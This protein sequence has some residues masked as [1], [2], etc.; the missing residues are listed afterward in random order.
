MDA[1][2]PVGPARPA[3][4]RMNQRGEPDVLDGP[5]RRRS[6][7]PRVESAGGDT[8]QLAHHPNRKG[9]LI[10]FHE[11]EDRFVVAV[12]ACANQAAAFDKIARSTF[13]CR[14]SRRSCVSSVRSAVVRPLDRR[15]T[16]RSAWATQLLID[17]AVSSNSRARSSG[18][19]PARTRATAACE[20]PADRASWFSASWTPSHVRVRCPRERGRSH[21]V[22]ATTQ[23]VSQMVSSSQEFVEAGR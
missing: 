19:R 7:H 23:L 12:V 1:W 8:Q 17:W 2:G 18:V 11:P 10:R 3:M 16:S 13:N 20:T 6:V 15:P 22:N 9:G 4:D 14:F 5:G 21:M